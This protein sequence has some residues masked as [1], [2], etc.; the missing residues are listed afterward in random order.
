MP[1]FLHTADWQLGRQFGRFE[2]EDAAMLSNER[3]EVVRR[4]GRLATEQAVDAVLVAGDLFDMQTVSDKLLGRAFN[5]M[6]GFSGP[7]IAIPGNHDAALAASVWTRAAQLGLLPANFHLLDEPVVKSFHDLDFAVLPAPLTQRQVAQDLTD[8]FDTAE[9]VPGL[10]R[11]GLAHGGVTGWLGDLEVGANPIAGD[12]VSTAKLDYLALGDWHSH[13][14]VNERCAYSGTP[15]ADSFRPANPG[16]VLDVSISAVGAPPVIT[17]HRVGRYNWHREVPDVHQQPMLEALLNKLATL[18]EDDVLRCRPAG[19]LSI[20]DRQRL[21][22]A[23]AR[24][25]ATTA[26]ADVDLSEILIAPSD[27]DFAE[28]Q[29]D[30]YVGIVLQDLRT[31]VP[32]Q[33]SAGNA[34]LNP[35]VNDAMSLL[36]ETLV[37]VSNR[38]RATDT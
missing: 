13:L 3:L 28:L 12:R 33:T 4:I 17:P 23:A 6:S 19:A 25:S 7:W 11:I 15:E 29:A 21:E 30:G 16:Y 5:A 35:V 34:E 8:W 36:S 1:R 38:T 26:A 31:E 14:S 22:H 18:T 20:A 10:L 37:R 24:A 32:A 2:T 27:E 9:T